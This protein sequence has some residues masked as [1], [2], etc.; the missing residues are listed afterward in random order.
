ME[1][2]AIGEYCIMEVDRRINLA[3][4]LL[5]H[6]F[7]STGNIVWETKLSH[8]CSLTHATFVP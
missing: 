2:R 8:L 1:N 3:W 4:P 6:T 7:L 5:M